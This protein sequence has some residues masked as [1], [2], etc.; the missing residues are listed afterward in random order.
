MSKIDEIILNWQNQIY[1]G[2][3][4]RVFIY[5]F[6]S[7]R[8]SKINFKSNVTADYLKLQVMFSRYYIFAFQIL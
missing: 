4:I 1:Y 6:N 3:L 8:Y 2:L 5:F 7:N